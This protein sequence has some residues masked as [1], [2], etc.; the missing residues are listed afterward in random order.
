MPTCLRY[1][2]SAL[3][4]FGA[5]HATPL[6]PHLML[7]LLPDAA[8][9][10]QLVGALHALQGCVLQLTNYYA[11]LQQHAAAEMPALRQVFKPG[12]PAPWP[13]WHGDLSY[14]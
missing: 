9:M 11:E 8:D 10:R 7:A 1:R 13:L 4:F 2:V 12:V 3:G 6:T 14:M 5:V